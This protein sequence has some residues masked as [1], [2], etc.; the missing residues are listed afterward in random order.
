M[1]IYFFEKNAYSDPLVVLKSDWFLIEFIGYFYILNIDSLSDKW[2]AKQWFPCHRLPFHFIDCFLCCAKLL[3]WCN[4]MSFLFL[5]SL[6]LFYSQRIVAKTNI[7]KHFPCVF[8]RSF[9]S[10]TSFYFCFFF[11]S[12]LRDIPAA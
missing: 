4:L 5:L 1:C 12:F 2:F 7:R 6:L 9:K 3:V 8:S 10:F 11:F